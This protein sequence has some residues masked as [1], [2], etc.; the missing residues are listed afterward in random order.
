PVFTKGFD[1]R[2]NVRGRTPLLRFDTPKSSFGEHNFMLRPHT[3][4]LFLCVSVC[5]LAAAF[6]AFGQDL[7]QVS[8]VGTVNDQ[9]G[10]PV[11]GAT[12]TLIDQATGSERNAVA[13]G[14]GRF[15]MLQVAPGS[16][17]LQAA[18]NGF[19]MWEAELASLFS[20]RE[21]VIP[22]ILV[23]AEVR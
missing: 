7:D 21:V 2:Q 23:P 9:N 6:S 1:L 10:L 17:V 20:G 13:D 8:I 11:A 4:L 18:A 12:L 14:T 22:V 3:R 19:G 5:I 15:R 16:Y